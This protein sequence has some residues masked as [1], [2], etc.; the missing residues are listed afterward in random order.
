MSLAGGGF[1][2]GWGKPSVTAEDEID[3]RNRS[4]LNPHQLHLRVLR[5]DLDFPCSFGAK[6]EHPMPRK[7]HTPCIRNGLPH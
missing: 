2:L 4:V 3:Q 6:R 1:S 7:L 5:R